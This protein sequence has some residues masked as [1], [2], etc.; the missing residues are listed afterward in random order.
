MI[1]L[2]SEKV[3]EEAAGGDL[4]TDPDTPRPW[5]ESSLVEVS[6]RLAMACHLTSRKFLKP[7]E[8][9]RISPIDGTDATI[10]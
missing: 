4:P 1:R 8:G 5:D 9:I 10:V 7:G 3:I 2:G 6:H